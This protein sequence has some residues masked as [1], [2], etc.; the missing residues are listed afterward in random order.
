LPT[1][2]IDTCTGNEA[3]IDE[4]EDGDE[5]EDEDEELAVKARAD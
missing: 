3:N 1:R 5:D 2:K 4:A